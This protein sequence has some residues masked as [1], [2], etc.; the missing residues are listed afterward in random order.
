MLSGLGADVWLEWLNVIRDES[1]DYSDLMVSGM[2]LIYDW[3][4]LMVS[5][6]GA[7]V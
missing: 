6:M 4:D 7:D 1:D 2:G 3:S 5:G